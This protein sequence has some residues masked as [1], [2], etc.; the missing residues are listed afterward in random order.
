MASRLQFQARGSCRWLGVIALA[1]TACLCVVATALPAQAVAF[2]GSQ[3]LT[4]DEYGEYTPITTQYEGDGVIFSGSSIGEPPFITWDGSN[5]TS[6][7]LSG[8]PRFHGTINAQFVAPGTPVQTTV[9][10]LAVDV[11][12]IDD[13]G[14]V[15][16]RLNTTTG[17]IIVPA[18]EFGINRLESTASNIAGFSVEEAEYDSAGFAIDNL[19]FTPGTPPAPPA[20]APPAAPAPAINCGHSNNWLTKLRLGIKCLAQ[21]PVVQCLAAI[22]LAKASKAL[23][24]FKAASGAY[25]LSEV[26]KALYPLAKLYNDLRKVYGDKFF[27]DAPVGYRSFKELK[28]TYERAK[29]VIEIVRV[30]PAL[31][32]AASRG[33][34]RE[35]AE[36]IADLAG[37]KSCV[38]ALVELGQ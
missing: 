38:Q 4:F 22:A 21:S 32:K 6:P 11:G 5:P 27:K 16:L 1:T 24:A 8:E 10:G 17:P 23:E 36:D 29:T 13:P 37:V 18:E 28:A 19:S 7:V 35:I 34:L 25:D 33:Q 30:V 20:A 31:A 14:S 26:S 2:S 3:T 9:N 12:Y 15:Q